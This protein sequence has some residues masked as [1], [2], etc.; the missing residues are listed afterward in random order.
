[1]THEQ[2]LDLIWD[3]E[4]TLL[5][6]KLR[7]HRSDRFARILA[8]FAN[9]QGGTLLIGVDDFGQIQGCDEERELGLLKEAADFYCS[10]P[11]DLEITSSTESGKTVLIV[12]IAEGEEKPYLVTKPDGSQKAYVRV[13]DKSL[14]VSKKMEHIFRNGK[15]LKSDRK[16]DSKE[17]ALLDYLVDH[18]RI[19]AFEYRRLINIGE[20]RARRILVKLL[21]EGLINYHEDGKSGYYTGWR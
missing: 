5:D 10:P 20:R 19:T 1:M 7:V 11:V 12:R 8:S 16:L 6:F 14:P 3:G 21:K 17:Q 18:E 15:F 13:D 9:N 2:I 4:G